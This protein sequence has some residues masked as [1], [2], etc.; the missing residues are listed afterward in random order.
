MYAFSRGIGVLILCVLV[1][2]AGAGDLNPPVGPITPTMKTL[3]EVEPRIAV[4]AVN[5]PGD[6]DSVFKITSPGS[7]YLVG[8]V[9]GAAGKSAVEIASDNVTL[10]LMGFDLIGVGGA[11]SGV[12]VDADLHENI[13]IRN[14]RVRDWPGYGIGLGPNARNAVLMDL[15]IVDNFGGVVGGTVFARCIARG[16]AGG[17]GFFGGAQFTD[18]QAIQ[19]GAVGYTA[20]ATFER[21][22]A[23]SN[24]GTGFASSG[25]ST[26]LSCT[27]VG[28]FGA[29]F[30]CGVTSTLTDCVAAGNTSGDGIAVG[31]HSTVTGCVSRSNV[32]RGIF[33]GSGCV[34]DDCQAVGNTGDGIAVTEGNITGCTSRSNGSDGISASSRSIIQRCTA[35]SNSG[36]GVQVNSGSRVVDN[37]CDGN[38]PAAATGSGVHVLGN[39]NRVEG[40][41]C[42][43]ND[44]GFDIAGGANLI[45]GNFARNNTG[46]P[47]NNYVVVAGNWFGTLTNDTT[48]NTDKNPHANFGPDCIP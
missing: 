13:V 20:S 14:G 23:Q 10:D 22:L 33:A 26:F 29:G 25:S 30:S 12:S 46:D 24:S 43:N 1:G 41:N 18:C 39:D 34:I 5:T 16:N 35:L 19:N 45:R 48:L 11:V 27:A 3:V 42:T 36:D 8:N 7:Y 28:N 2:R 9:T 40:N 31:D 38:G 32:G 15:H 4:T 47:C 17:G 21:C 6:A 44:V 37:T